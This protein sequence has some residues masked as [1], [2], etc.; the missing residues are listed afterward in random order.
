MAIP[1]P[2]I[3]I[4]CMAVAPGVLTMIF[5]ETALA[6]FSRASDLF[7]LAMPKQAGRRMWL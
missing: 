3:S 2:I 1:I 5:M 7:V 4:R 6:T